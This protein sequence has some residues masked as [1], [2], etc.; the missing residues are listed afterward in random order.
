MGDT[1]T[2]EKSSAPKS[3]WFKIRMAILGILLLALVATLVFDW[4][5]QKPAMSKNL[6]IV[7]KMFSESRGLKQTKGPRPAYTPEDVENAIG[8]KAATERFSGDNKDVKI[9]TYEWNRGLPLQLVFGNDEEE[10]KDEI[11]ADLDKPT[12]Q[13]GPVGIKSFPKYFFE[14]V[15]K[16]EKYLPDPEQ[17]DKW[18][19]RFVLYKISGE[20]TRVSYSPLGKMQMPKNPPKELMMPSAPG[21]GG[22][23]PAKG[24]KGK[25][26][27]PTK[28]DGKKDDKSDDK[29]SDSKSDD[30]KDDVKSDD[31][32]ED[33]KKDDQ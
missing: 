22:S 4:L 20:N 33:D 6:E 12:L 18:A 1:N 8:R 11:V 23:R 17:S 10:G 32:K 9:M 21:G 25:T 2:S 24:K 7:D 31:K 29:K 30:K 3:P 16:K 5:V 15:F 19:E 26:K 27:R 13:I 14:A 28:D